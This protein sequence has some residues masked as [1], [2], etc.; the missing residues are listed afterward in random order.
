MKS[1]F[2][3]NNQSVGVKD[4]WCVVV[5]QNYKNV[6]ID[7][8]PPLHHTSQPPVNCSIL[9]SVSDRH[10]SL[11]RDCCYGNPP[12]PTL[13]CGVISSILRK[14]AICKVKW[15]K[16]ELNLPYAVYSV[17]SSRMEED[18]HW[19]NEMINSYEP[20]MHQWTSP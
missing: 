11:L 15:R 20:T 12:P 2:L 4:M 16:Q 6:R 5:K 10:F 8:F 19:L 7:F 1:L 13:R 18:P 9:Q 3:F 14:R 17:C